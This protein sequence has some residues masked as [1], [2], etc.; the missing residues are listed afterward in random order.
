[1]TQLKTA[2]H[3]SGGRVSEHHIASA[4]KD[5]VIK[6]IPPRLGS[7]GVQ[8]DNTFPS[9][10]A[11]NGYGILMAD[12]LKLACQ[13]YVGENFW[14]ALQAGEWL[15]TDAPFYLEALDMDI[16]ISE[17]MTSAAGRDINFD[18]RGMRKKSR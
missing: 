9:F 10:A 13:D 8:V 7:Y 1:M 17:F 16:E 2:Y 6:S 12:I 15:L 14:I 4:H 18:G 3:M 11:I 5:K